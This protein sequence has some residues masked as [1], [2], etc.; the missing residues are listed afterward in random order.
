MP[1][2]TE[3]IILDHMAA[4]AESA[5][6]R[7][8]SL[9]EDRELTVSDLCAVLQLPQSTVSRHLKALLDRGWVE[10]RADGTSRLYRSRAG[11]LDDAARGLWELTRGQIEQTPERQ[12]DRQRLVSV[13]ARHRSRSREF[14]DEKSDRWDAIRDEMYGSHFYLQALLGLLPSDWTVAELGCGTGAI[15]EALAPFVRR[16]V[17]VDASSPMLDLAQRRLERFD[18]VDLLPGELES[19]PL[20]DG[21]VDVATMILVLHNLER[22]EAAIAEAARCLRPNGRLLIVDMLPHDRVEYRM[23]RGHV[24]MGFSDKMING[25]LESAGFGEGRFRPLPP[26]PEAKGPNL[27]AVSADLRSE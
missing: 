2:H 4:L 26:A 16:V 20:E 8:L 25:Y 27:F 23:E 6:C 1:N 12:Q 18:N 13:L 21:E 5:R 22:P 7:L 11:E 14:F 24:W 15:A 10:A 17:G 3:P 9:L 19:L